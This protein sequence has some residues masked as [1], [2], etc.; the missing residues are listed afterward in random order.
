M[1]PEEPGAKDADGKGGGELHGAEI[2]VS[3]VMGEVASMLCYTGAKIMK[4]AAAGAGPAPAQ[5][6]SHAQSGKSPECMCAA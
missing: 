3:Q 2:H 4:E 1:P 6:R 5:L